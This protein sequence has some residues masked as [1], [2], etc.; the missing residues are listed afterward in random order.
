MHGGSSGSALHE[1]TKGYPTDAMKA[2]PAAWGSTI[3]SDK[4]GPEAQGSDF[5]DKLKP[6]A[7]Q[8]DVD[9]DHDSGIAHADSSSS[10]ISSHLKRAFRER[11][12]LKRPT[13]QGTLPAARRSV[14]DKQ[15]KH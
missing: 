2:T 5:A 11:S 9:H 14:R 8:C 6:A 7:R 15:P 1:P 10:S 12:G 4:S 13:L 3:Q